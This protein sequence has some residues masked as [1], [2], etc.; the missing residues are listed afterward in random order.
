M[1]YYFLLGV[2]VLLIIVLMIVL[3]L[4]D[5]CEHGIRLADRCDDCN[6]RRRA[7]YSER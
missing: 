7:G 2:F 4:D 6:E 1:M 3:L 5:Y